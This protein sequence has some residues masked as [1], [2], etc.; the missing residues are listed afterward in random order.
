MV[1]KFQ[2]QREH[3]LF[4]PQKNLEFRFHVSVITHFL[5]QSVHAANVSLMSKSMAAH[6]QSHKLLAPFQSNQT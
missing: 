1:L 5:I 4:A 2:F 6:F 3:L